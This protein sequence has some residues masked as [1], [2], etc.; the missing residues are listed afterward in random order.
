M[1]PQLTVERRGDFGIRGIDEQG[2]SLRERLADQRYGG[3]DSV[4][5]AVV[6][7]NLGQWSFPARFSR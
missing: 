7:K 3:G 1:H 5:G 4:G 6:E 2:F